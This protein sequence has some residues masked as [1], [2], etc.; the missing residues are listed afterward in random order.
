ML[1]MQC[2]YCLQLVTEVLA[3]HFTGSDLTKAE[4]MYRTVDKITR[5]L[6]HYS[7]FKYS[8]NHS[9]IPSWVVLQIIKKKTIMTS[10]L[11]ENAA[12]KNIALDRFETSREHCLCSLRSEELPNSMEDLINK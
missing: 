4:I 6:V 10:S 12:L 1:G 9:A 3:A 5:E 2:C 8:E 11:E 7:F